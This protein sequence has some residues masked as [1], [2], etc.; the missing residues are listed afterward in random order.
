MKEKI[1]L[2]VLAVAIAL[3]A[4][5]ANAWAGHSPPPD[6]LEL[7]SF[8]IYRTGTPNLDLVEEFYRE[9]DIRD[10]K[11]ASGDERLIAFAGV[12]VDGYYFLIIAEE[13]WDVI[14]ETVEELQQIMG[15]DFPVAIRVGTLQLLADTATAPRRT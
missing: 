3:L 15:E 13:N 8:D 6:D 14:Y 5:G 7:A 9:F 10:L 2:G 1:K 4:M 11:Y 12:R